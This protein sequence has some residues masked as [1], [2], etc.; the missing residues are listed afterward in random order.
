MAVHELA[1]NSLVHGGGRGVLRI[2][3][4]DDAV[5]CEVRDSGYID[6]PGIG[7]R[8]PDPDCDSGRGLWIVNQLCDLVQIRSSAEG[9]TIRV[10]IAIG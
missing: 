8:L 2:W 3:R 5:V 1:M 9:T 10:H 6:D 4:D 7:R